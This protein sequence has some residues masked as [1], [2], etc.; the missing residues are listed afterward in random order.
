M[1]QFGEQTVIS[2]IRDAHRKGGRSLA[3]VERILG[4]T[5][6]R[7]SERYQPT[8]DKDDIEAIMQDEWFN[9]E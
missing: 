4:D 2:A 3:Y 7:Q 5:A 9:E 1:K 8:Y 6:Q